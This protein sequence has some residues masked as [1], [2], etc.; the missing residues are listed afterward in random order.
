MTITSQTKIISVYK[1][2]SGEIIGADFSL[3]FSDDSSPGVTSEG[4]GFQP[5]ASP[6]PSSASEAE[7]VVAVDQVMA[8]Q[9]PGL[10]G[11]H[12]EQIFLRHLVETSQKVSLGPVPAVTVDLVNAERDRRIATRFVF[13]GKAFAFDPNSKQRVTGAATLAGFAIANGAQPGN[14]DWQGNGQPFYWIA[15]DNSLVQMDAQTCFTFGREAAAHE[16]AHIFAA[17][18]LKDMNPIPQDYAND[19]YWP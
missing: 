3:I 15:D 4:R 2:A 6:L 7:I 16:S 9:L 10:L 19:Q 1:D 13:N 8:P 5:F 18:T 11:F 17:R 12:Q 14:P